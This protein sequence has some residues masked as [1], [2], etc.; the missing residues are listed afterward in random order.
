MTGRALRLADL[1]W[2][3][4]PPSATVVVPVGSLEQHGPHLPLETDALVA[5]AVAVR[6]V[7]ALDRDDVLVAPVVAYGASGEHQHF[8]GTVS[9]GTPVLHLLLVELVRS[10][11][12][13]ATRVVLVNGHGGNLDAVRGAVAQLV[14]E[15]HDVAWAP[16][17]AA[18]AD[19]HA[20]RTETSL[21]LH[22]RPDL[23]RLDHAAAGAT[24]PAA[25]LM[26]LLRAGGVVAV[27]AN[28]VLGDPAGASAEEG[29]ALLEEMVGRVLAVLA[30]PSPADPV[31][32]PVDPVE[33]PQVAR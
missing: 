19:L 9:T 11:R 18:G 10:L 26:P 24:A 16:C 15:G 20:G 29:R 1:T 30:L 25:E 28:G 21:L 2:P 12:T 27:S 8:A 5:E 23:V 33:T 14:D 4:L 17:A 22:L 3:E 31:R 13:W 6:A 7:A 32:A